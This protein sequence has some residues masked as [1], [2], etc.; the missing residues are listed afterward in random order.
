MQGEL[1]E[2]RQEYELLRMHLAYVSEEFGRHQKELANHQVE[3]ERL[4]E[5][6]GNAYGHA[7]ALERHVEELRQR[8]GQQEQQIAQAARLQAELET[9]QSSRSWRLTAPLRRLSSLLKGGERA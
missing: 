5:M 9:L 4:R 6:L 7:Q 1:V 2:L 8:I 3:V